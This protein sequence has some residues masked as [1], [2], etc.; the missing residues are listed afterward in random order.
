MLASL[1]A[2]L[3]F[4]EIISSSSFIFHS[5]FS[6]L[7]KFIS[8]FSSKL[9]LITIM[10]RWHSW[11]STTA[12]WCSISHLHMRLHLAKAYHLYATFSVVL[13]S[14]LDF[15]PKIWKLSS[16]RYARLPQYYS[17]W[18]SQCHL[19]IALWLKEQKISIFATWSRRICQLS[20]HHDFIAW[21]GDV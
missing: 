13:F 20:Y 3:Y 10:A 16:S 5:A 15:T 8:L 17:S 7:L 4:K 21:C 2:F 19:Q 9:Y 6:P 11:L 18:W 12:V 1:L 14:H